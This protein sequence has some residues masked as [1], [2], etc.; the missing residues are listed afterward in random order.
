MLYHCPA[1]H[2]P[3]QYGKRPIRDDFLERRIT[4][5]HSLRL[6]DGGG[7]FSRLERP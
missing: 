2:K 4:G 3:P 1:L 5:L 7:Y 6:H